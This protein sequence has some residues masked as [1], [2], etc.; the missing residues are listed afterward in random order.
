MPKRP[1]TEMKT[2]KTKKPK[3]EVSFIFGIQCDPKK[4][5][6]LKKALER[7]TL[8]REQK[9][10][11][12]QYILNAVRA[13]R[14][15]SKLKAPKPFTPAEI[16]FM[17]KHYEGVLK[18]LQ[19]NG[20]PKKRIELVNIWVRQTKKFDDYLVIE[21]LDANNPRQAL[22]ALN[23]YATEMDY[24][25]NCPFLHSEVAGFQGGNDLHSRTFYRTINNSTPI[26]E[27]VH[28]MFSKDEYKTS[29]IEQYYA[30]KTGLTNSRSINR[31]YKKGTF[32]RKGFEDAF[33]LYVMGK[34]KGWQVADA[35]LRKIIFGK[36]EKVNYRVR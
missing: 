7:N 11:V 29:L 9:K 27:F 21:L 28:R 10:F 14:E 35:E 33:K 19:P 16:S 5:P 31:S 12:E 6:E 2:N 17:Q 23:E 26:H 1:K 25:L 22:Q 34:K 15:N 36:Q 13:I 4:F 18:L 8:T 3:I 30:L 20:D 32:Y 24:P